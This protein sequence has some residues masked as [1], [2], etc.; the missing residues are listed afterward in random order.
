MIAVGQIK[1][2]QK[3]EIKKYVEIINNV[4]YLYYIRQE[5]PLI[6]SGWDEL[7]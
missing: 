2:S 4:P 7:P 6:F 5:N 3:S 1:L